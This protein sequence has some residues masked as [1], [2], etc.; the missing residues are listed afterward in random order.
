FQCSAALGRLDDV[1][2]QPVLH[3]R[4]GIEELGLDVERYSVDAEIVDA[5]C[6]GVA[7]GIVDAVEQAAATGGGSDLCARCHAALR[8]EM[9]FG[10]II[11]GKSRP[12]SSEAP[13]RSL[14]R[15]WRGLR[16]FGKCSNNQARG[17][18]N[19]PSS[20]YISPRLGT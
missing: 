10:S 4:R 12:M 11:L 5:D 1:E 13:P 19:P 8:F 9:P 17:V 18:H 7:D 15:I 14:T 16:A 2:R 3:R 6:R 20:C